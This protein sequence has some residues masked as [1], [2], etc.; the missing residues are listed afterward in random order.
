[1]SGVEELGGGEDSSVPVIPRGGM[2]RTDRHMGVIT[3]V[4]WGHDPRT[5]LP[6]LR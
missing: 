3:R 5:P 1:M 6:V 4:P 2:L